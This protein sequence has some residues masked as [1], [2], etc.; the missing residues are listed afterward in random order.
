V[1]LSMPRG[2]RRKS[3]SGIYHVIL[4]GANRQEIFHDEE[5]CIR[6]LDIMQRYKWKSDMKIFGWCLMNNHVHLLIKEGNEDLS[7]T[8]KRM[9]VSYVWYYNEKY[10]TT[11]HL[12]Q[13]RFKSEIVEDNRALLTVLRYIHQNPVKAGIVSRVDEWQW[14]SCLGYYGKSYY[15]SGLLDADFILEKISNNR[16]AA[17]ESFK[18]YNE[19][20]NHDECLDDNN[21]KRRLR[22]NEARQEIRNLLGDVEITQVKSLPRQ[23][24]NELLQQIKT[25]RGLSQRQAARILGISPN[26]IFRA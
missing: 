21:P 6:F 11:G 18:E 17:R 24:R 26:L 2:A 22:D 9:E 19:K 12:F 15:P 5:D 8:M 13:G 25:I 1:L 3:L 23:Q 7:T 14:C 20:N 4:R 10:D 16:M